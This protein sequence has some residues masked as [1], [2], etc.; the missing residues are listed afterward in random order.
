MILPCA[1]FPP[2]LCRRLTAGLSCSPD[3]DDFDM[4]E[5]LK[6]LQPS[7]PPR[8][9]EMEPRS[10]RGLVGDP[11]VGVIPEGRG[12]SEEESDSDGPILY[13][14]DDE[15]VP[16]SKMDFKL[17][18][19]VTKL[20][21]S[22]MTAFVSRFRRAGEPGQEEGHLGHEAG[23][24]GEGGAGSS[25]EPGRPELEQQGAVGGDEE[26]DRDHSDQVGYQRRARWIRPAQ[27]H[28]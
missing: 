25:G 12:D 11:R 3:D 6:K 13:R 4:E 22:T 16:I 8:Q 5:E 10:R 23:A 9:P 19:T 21:S 27:N 28:L 26:Q 20:Q 14:D 1:G 18:W 15:D 17:A 24:T 2:E 7:R